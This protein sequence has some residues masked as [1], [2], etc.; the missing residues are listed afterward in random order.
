[1]EVLLLK[2]FFDTFYSFAHLR[3]RGFLAPKFAALYNHFMRSRAGRTDAALPI[4]ADSA[5][6]ASSG[7]KTHPCP[8][9]RPRMKAW[10][11]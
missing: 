11:F 8:A 4:F 7:R 9:V 1:M 3:A 5:P 10:V 2:I 6:D